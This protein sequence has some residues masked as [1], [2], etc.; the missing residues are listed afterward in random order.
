MAQ[1]A[2][3]PVRAV[4][5]WVMVSRREYENPF[6]DVALDAE[7]VSPSGVV[8]T[9]PGFYD[10]DGVWRVR[11]SPGEPGRWSY[12]IAATPADPELASDGS[13]EVTPRTTRGFLRATPGEAWGFRYESG[14]PVLLVGDTVYNLFA[15]TY[16]GNDVRPYLRRRAGQGFNLLRMSLV[17]QPFCP[18]NAYTKWADRRIWPWG[19]SEWCP[20][21]DRFDLRYFRA[22]DETVRLVDEAGLGI[23]MIM[24]MPGTG[25]P[26]GRRDLFTAEAEELWIRYLLARYDAYPSVYFWTLA[27]EYEYL[28][29]EYRHNP[30]ADRWALRVARLVKRLAPHGHPVTVHSGPELPPFAS[31]F[32]ANPDAVDVIMYQ[33]WG[34]TGPND[35]WLAAGIE[36][37][38]TKALAGWA[39]SAVFAEYGYETSPEL[40]DI[41]P[42]HGHL[43]PDHTRR[44]AWRGA[45]CG[46]G[47]VAGFHQQWWGFG[48][49]AVDQPGVAALTHLRHF[50]TDVLAFEEL[51]P[52]GDLIL[53]GPTEPGHRPLVLSSVDR[54]VV[55]VYLPVGGEVTLDLPAAGVRAARWYDPRL[56][57][58]T[59]AVVSESDRGLAAKSPGGPHARPHD[60][61]LVLTG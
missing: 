54:R 10:G 39:G 2:V 35:A 25:S 36:D 22:V 15:E 44:G 37:T 17:V 13:V 59:E 52:V 50:L 53:D 55:A 16:L 60:W 29:N 24:E 1:Q 19:G 8:H 47:V 14:E 46:V 4:G 56:G 26:F 45:F 32:R 3:L 9:V 33:T 41:M 48:D 40:A 20:Q 5:E 34:T 27:N 12:R 49:Y 38:I 23:E 42:G 21:F 28:T 51:R 7:F 43:D 57:E 61:T 31:R 11:F 58:L 18:P 6:V 30:A